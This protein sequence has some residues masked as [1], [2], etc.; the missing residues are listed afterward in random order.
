MRVA[1][2][3]F[4][5]MWEYLFEGENGDHKEAY[6]ELEEEYTLLYRDYHD[7]NHIEEGVLY[8]YKFD[9]WPE[10]ATGLR[11]KWTSILA[12]FYH[13]FDNPRNTEAEIKS[14]LKMQ[15]IVI[16]WMDYTIYPPKHIFA[17]VMGMVDHA[18]NAIVD[19]ATHESST[20]IGQMVID[21]DLMRFVEGDWRVWSQQIRN[22]YR[23][24]SD[25]AFN[26]GRRVV[27]ER[28]RRRSPFFY[29]VQHRD[30]DAYRNLDEQIAE[31]T[32]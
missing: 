2:F 4:S 23:E 24:Y 22:E 27:L 9:K 13:D 16:D 8:L 30:C 17:R 6:R 1:E 26:A 5:E 15:A 18:Y 29:F 25:E 19:T 7:I 31:L 14:A 21:A 3:I 28:F 32:T 10:G 20:I 12:F 11:M